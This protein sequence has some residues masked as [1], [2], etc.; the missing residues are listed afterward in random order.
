MCLVALRLEG[1]VLL[2]KHHLF[3]LILTEA[4]AG[5]FRA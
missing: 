5:F 1:P 3:Y 4:M 2:S